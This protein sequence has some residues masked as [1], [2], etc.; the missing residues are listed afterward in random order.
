VKIDLLTL[1]LFIRVVDEGTISRA[2]ELENIAAAAVS[3]R[4]SELEDKLG[5]VLL[6]RTNRGVTPTPAGLELLYRGRAILNSVQAVE[7]QLGDFGKGQRGS[8]TLAANPTAITQFLAPL[9]ADFSGKYPNIQL[10]LEEK[11]S[12]SITRELA[13]G[14]L[15][16]GIFTQI[17]YQD[18]IEVAHFRTDTL[19]VLVPAG[20][21]LAKRDKVSFRETLS[22]S[23]IT[24][25]AGT[26]LNY[27]LIN[28][29]RAESANV[30]IDIETSGYD[31]MC[32]LINANMGIGILP[33]GCVDLYRV[34]DTARVK[35]DEE[36]AERKILIGA[37]RIRDLS[38]SARQVF[39]FLSE[40]NDSIL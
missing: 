25:T 3:R 4:L 13:A 40:N 15:D 38:A 34:P 22:Y 31:A 28:A 7:H 33:E 9:L 26:Q 29:A 27:Q 10:H 32:V 14:K 24:L 8:V 36:W 18:D 11:N 21:P 2:A 20:H 23:H 19:I 17:P 35:L 12:L 6:N 37:R 5:L 39:D 16:I 30:R 1:K